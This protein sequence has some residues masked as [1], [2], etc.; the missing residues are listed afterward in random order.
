ME[1]GHKQNTWLLPGERNG[2]VSFAAVFWDVTSQNSAAKEAR[3]G[4]AGIDQRTEL[5]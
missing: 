2:T 3:N 1:L 4:T 5:T